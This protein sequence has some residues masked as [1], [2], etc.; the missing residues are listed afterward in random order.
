MRNSQATPDVAPV[1]LPAICWQASASRILA[2]QSL[3]L[4]GF[5]FWD[6]WPCVPI[7]GTVCGAGCPPLHH[8]GLGVGECEEVNAAPAVAIG[9]VYPR[10]PPSFIPDKFGCD[11]AVGNQMPAAL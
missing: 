7:E 9:A 1:R 5:D 10:Q 4:V 6:V 11:L 3:R 2:K 8:A